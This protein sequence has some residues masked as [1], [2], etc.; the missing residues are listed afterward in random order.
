MSFAPIF[1]GF[2]SGGT[3]GGTTNDPHWANV[4]LLIDHSDR[5]E[6]TDSNWT[7][8]VLVLDHSKG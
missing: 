8:V 7:S 1:G 6:G 4:V 5:G 2:G 3:T